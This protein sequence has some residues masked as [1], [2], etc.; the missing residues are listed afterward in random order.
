MRLGV[1]GDQTRFFR[2]KQRSR[3]SMPAKLKKTSLAKQSLDFVENQFEYI[4]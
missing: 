4:A 3:T 1:N 2:P